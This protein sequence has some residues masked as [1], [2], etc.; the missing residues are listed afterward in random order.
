M[1]ASNPAVAV[2]ASALM[3][4][5]FALT[6]TRAVPVATRLTPSRR[7]ATDQILKHTMAWTVGPVL[8]TALAGMKGGAWGY[9]VLFAGT[10]PLC[11]RAVVI[12]AWT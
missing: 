8:G 2:A 9:G 7:C 12:V 3:G 4:A 1:M 11:A 5:A 10:C 6:N